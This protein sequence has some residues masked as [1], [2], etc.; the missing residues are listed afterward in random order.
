MIAKYW[1]LSGRTIESVQDI[2]MAETQPEDLGNP[3][4]ADTMHGPSNAIEV[5]GIIIL[6][7]NLGL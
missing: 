1:F 3:I 5:N 7:D 4:R 6:S 2:S